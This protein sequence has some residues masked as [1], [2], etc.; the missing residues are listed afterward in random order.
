MGNLD[1]PS[2]V[3]I[4]FKFYTHGGPG[5]T[6]VLPTAKKTASG[7]V[8]TRPTKPQNKRYQIPE[9]IKLE[10]LNPNSAKE[11]YDHP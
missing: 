6:Q 7:F 2:S 3:S 5:H 9:L 4:L 1:I 8:H 10:K 11:F